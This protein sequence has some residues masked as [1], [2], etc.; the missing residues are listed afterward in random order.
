MRLT[1]PIP[2]LPPTGGFSRRFQPWN[3][4]IPHDTFIFQNCLFIAWS[5]VGNGFGWEALAILALATQLDP[6]GLGSSHL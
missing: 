3:T 1:L 6:I 2:V 4:Y 5:M